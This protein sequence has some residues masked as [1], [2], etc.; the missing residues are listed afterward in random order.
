M[1]PSLTRGR[2]RSLESASL[3]DPPSLPAPS[4]RTAL[5]LRIR[6]LPLSRWFLLLALPVGTFLVFVTPP[7]LGLDEPNHFFRTYTIAGGDLVAP[8]IQG[9]AGGELGNCLYEYVDRTLRQ[10]REPGPISRRTFFRSPG[11]CEERATR[12]VPF[13]NTAL[14]SPISY[15]PQAVAVGLGRATGLPVPAIFYLGRMATLLAYVLLVWFALRLAPVGRRY[16]FVLGLMP[17]SLLLAS[18][19]SA[20]SLAIGLSTLVVAL[21]LRCIRSPEATLRTFVILVVALACLALT[22]HIYFVLAPLLLL[23][24]GDLFESQFRSRVVKG[25]ALAL[26]TVVSAFWLYQVRDVTLAAYHAPGDVDPWKQFSFVIHHP[27]RFLGVIGTS[28]SDQDYVVPGFV[29]AMGVARGARAPLAPPMVYVTAFVLMFLSLRAETGRRSAPGIP[30]RA[31]LPLGLLVA[32]IVAVEAALYLIWTPIGAPAVEGVQGRYFLPLAGLPLV[33]VTLLREPPSFDRRA[34]PYVVG[35]M[36]LLC[37]C[38]AKVVH[39][40]Y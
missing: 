9:Q 40:F 35:M 4:G 24:R 27:A 36:L 38:G 25:M 6:R 32:G 15:L 19:Y 11:N 30:V 21:T 22:K 10:A 20:D 37:W 1:I 16:L 3:D 33:A 39:Y 23:A 18:T 8:S 5:S 13:E 12:F 26:V 31:L 7:S 17:M 2:R 29:G 34:W 14:H 28:L